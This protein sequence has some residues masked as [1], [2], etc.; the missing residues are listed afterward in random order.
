MGKK[1]LFIAKINEPKEMPSY[2]QDFIDNGYEVKIYSI[3][4]MF[5]KRNILVRLKKRIGLDIRNNVRARKKHLE[6][7]IISIVNTYEPDIVCVINGMMLNT[8]CAESI[9]ENSFLVAKMI[10]RISFFPEYYEDGFSKHYDVIY[11]YSLDDYKII[12]SISH[13]CVFIPAMWEE[14][15]YHNDC[16]ERDIDISFVGKMYPEKDY[17]KRYSTFCKLIKDFPN[18][19]I[20]IGGECAPIRRI[21]KYIEWKSTPLYKRAFNNKQITMTECNEV[22]NRTKISISMERFGTGNSWSSRLINLF[23]TGSF[24]LSS[25][26][27]EM[28]NKYFNNC[29]VHFSDYE[30]LKEKI[31]YYLSHEKERSEIAARAYERVYEVKRSSINISMTEDIITRVNHR[32]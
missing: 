10:D 5:G 6:K 21:K 2:I 4:G 32:R 15:V 16:L 11:T 27:S 26:N 19:N 29:F 25:D 28:L 8:H 13:N 3:S 17:G 18:L 31:V 7:K 12:N 1:V 9:R 20:F 24:V 23:A 14:N 30:D 22:Y